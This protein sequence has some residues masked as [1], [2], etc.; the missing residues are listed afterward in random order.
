MLLYVWLP[1]MTAMEATKPWHLDHGM[2]H[3]AAEE[4]VEK[5]ANIGCT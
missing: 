5:T 2:S 1:W 3:I 4:A